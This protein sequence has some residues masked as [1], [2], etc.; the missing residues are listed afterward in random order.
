MN[1]V[2]Q[3]RGAALR[4]CPVFAANSPEAAA[5][6]FNF[7]FRVCDAAASPYLAL[8][9]LLF[10]GAEGLRRR[11]DL[12]PPGSVARP[13]PGSLGAALDALEASDAAAMWFGPVFLEAYLRHKRA[14]IAHVGEVDPAALCARYAE[15]Y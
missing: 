6:H 12:P 1:A 13:L 2:V 15:V 3:D 11:L 4:V 8:G 10:A 9:A 14:E 5:R 7:E